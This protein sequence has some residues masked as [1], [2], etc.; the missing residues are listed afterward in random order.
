MDA[1]TSALLVFSGMIACLT[2]GYHLGY[3]LGKRNITKK[4]AA[5]VLA[6]A[7]WRNR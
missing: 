2:V 6:K 3:G 7:S 5:R 1:F 4:D